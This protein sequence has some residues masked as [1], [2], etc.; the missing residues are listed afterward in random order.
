M[1]DAKQEESKQEEPKQEEPKQVE[2]KQ[3]EPKEEEPKQ[4]EP[5][6]L[7]QPK[8]IKIND[9]SPASVGVNFHCKVSKIKTVI[10]R[11]NL[12]GSRLRISEALI[13]DETGLIL[14][15]LRNDQIDLVKE[16]MSLIMR[17]AKV[18]MVNQG[19]MRVAGMS[20]FTVCS[21]YNEQTHFL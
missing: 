14:L 8:F 21:V 19:H 11:L 3:E 9:L 12:D 16:G 7:S 10:N 18:D 6:K 13:G 5:I 1:A 2:P 20:L 15:S 17:N 4:P